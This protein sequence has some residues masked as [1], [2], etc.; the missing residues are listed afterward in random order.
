[1]SSPLAHAFNWAQEEPVAPVRLDPLLQMARQHLA[2]W[3][4]TLP[5]PWSGCILFF[6]VASEKESATVFHVKASTFESAWR[7]GSIRIRQWAWA[8]RL[9]TV[10]LRIDWVDSVAHHPAANPMDWPSLLQQ[11][12]HSLALADACLEDI[13]LL[14]QAMFAEEDTTPAWM[15][16]TLADP[17]MAQTVLLLQLRGVYLDGRAPTAITLPRNQPTRSF[18]RPLAPP[19]E[20]AWQG[21]RTAARLTLDN[22]ITTQTPNGTWQDAHG[23][24]DHLGILHTLLQTLEHIRS[25]RMPALATEVLVHAIA[26]ATEYAMEHASGQTHVSAQ[27]LLVLNSIAQAHVLGVRHTALLYNLLDQLAWQLLQDAAPK[28]LE[29]LHTHAPA[30]IATMWKSLALKV[31]WTYRNTNSGSELPFPTEPHAHEA[32]WLP[33]LLISS[34]SSPHR[35]FD[36]LSIAVIEANRCGILAN[37][38]PHA[39]AQQC[40][41]I[42]Q[43][44]QALEQRIIWPELAIYLGSPRRAQTPFFSAAHNL[45][46]L[47]AATYSP[48]QQANV[49]SR[50]SA[51]HTLLGWL[52]PA[53][54]QETTPTVSAETSKSALTS[55][56]HLAPMA[57][58]SQ[59]LATLTKGQWIVPVGH[60]VPAFIAGLTVTRLQHTPNAAVLLR[61]S[62]EITGVLP[63][64]V[65]ALHPQALI[66]A[67]STTPLSAQVPVLHMPELTLA[68]NRWATSARQRIHVPVIAAT[69][70][71]GKSSTLRMLMQCLGNACTVQ[72]EALLQSETALQMINWSDS[73]PCVLAE[74]GPSQALSDLSILR[75]DIL[76]VTNFPED[77][78]QPPAP[79]K[80]KN[81]HHLVQ[82]MQHLRAGS[83][84]V[85]NYALVPLNALHSAA[86]QRGIELIGFGPHPQAQ[87][88]ELFYAPLGRLHL[89]L[90]PKPA[91]QHATPSEKKHIQ[92]RADGHHMALNAQ[93]ALAVLHAIRHPIDSAI[94]PLTTWKPPPG[95]GQPENL[96]VNRCLLDHSN[97]SE[98]L[99]VQAAMQQLQT[100][101]PHAHQRLIVLGGIKAPHTSIEDAQLQLEPLIRST[102]AKHVFLYGNAM[103]GLT[104]SLQ[105]QPH[106]HWFEDLNQLIHALLR[107]FDVRHTVLLAGRTTT[108]LSIVA[109]AIRE[110]VF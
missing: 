87:V 30:D 102:A 44:W 9:E 3:V 75:P 31:Y 61:R 21:W 8:R 59:S 4:R 36:W 98:L 46:N 100:H 88:R 66:S 2:V 62:G 84:L 104:Q 80:E 15:Q 16:P 42:E 77:S 35:G 17:A 82:L 71:V 50:L 96:P 43:Q 20:C 27:S 70:C 99:A 26:L 69:G 58:S 86:Q 48:S 52:E 39:S 33:L 14:P 10:L 56:S 6:S 29:A 107:A 22:L 91:Q 83:T 57:W 12:T 90:P 24:L 23:L 34:G 11:N 92:L 32:D 97:T 65:A 85:L 105:D 101:A 7:E 1:M 109:S 78:A 5:E 103:L 67:D 68:I 93:A 108:N 76:V 38:A 89:Q 49:L 54:I 74:L 110:N 94:A 63:A 106:V 51:C 47:Q 40:A 60:K 64:S 81:L 73:A 41:A 45:Q 72:Q 19:A 25:A 37:T 79:S 53:S 18:T 55:S 95:S 13:W 28:H